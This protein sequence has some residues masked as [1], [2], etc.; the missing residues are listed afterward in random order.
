MARILVVDDEANILHAYREILS[1][2]GHEVHLAKDSK[3]ALSLYYRYDFDVAV[4]DIF[5]G[6]DSGIDLLPALRKTSKDVDVIIITGKPHQD[7]QG[8]A[9][10]YGVRSYLIKPVSALAIRR[11]VAQ[12]LKDRTSV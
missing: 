8:Q 3:E 1:N 7:T 2:D 12:T 5:L 4:I 11:V 6:G 9:F 10:K